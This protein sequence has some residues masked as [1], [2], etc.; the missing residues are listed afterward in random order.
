MGIL[1]LRCWL[2][3]SSM[4]E[5]KRHVKLMSPKFVFSDRRCFI[6]KPFKIANPALWRWLP[7]GFAQNIPNRIRI[8]F[9]RP[10]FRPVHKT[11]TKPIL[12]PCRG[13]K[14]KSVVFQASE[15]LDKPILIAQEGDFLA[16]VT[17]KQ[18]I[19]IEKQKARGH[20]A[21]S[22]YVCG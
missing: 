19:F 16:R 6:Q 9:S 11:I 14:Q 4:A 12:D 7:F 8:Q 5:Q 2:L 21:F 13:F 15:N 3:S 17:S 20:R 18:N 22:M 1:N 10:S